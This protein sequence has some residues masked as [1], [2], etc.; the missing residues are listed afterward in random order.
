MPRLTLPMLTMFRD[1]LGPKLVARS[2]VQVSTWV[3]GTQF[4]GPSL[5]LLPRAQQEAGV[6][7]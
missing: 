1:E 2:L 3:A 4:P 7:S 5:L 6:R